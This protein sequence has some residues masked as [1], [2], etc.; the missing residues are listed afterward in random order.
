MTSSSRISGSSHVRLEL[1]VSVAIVIPLAYCDDYKNLQTLSITYR[2]DL[3]IFSFATN[4]LYHDKNS[5]QPSLDLI[6]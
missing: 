1:L 3:Q 2:A 5:L 4:I 6:G